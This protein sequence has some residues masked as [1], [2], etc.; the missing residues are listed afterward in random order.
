[1]KTLKFLS[2]KITNTI[3]SLTNRNSLN[4][5]ILTKSIS[6]ENST[7]DYEQK[8]ETSIE[9]TKLILESIKMENNL[10][11]NNNSSLRKNIDKLDK[12]LSQIINSFFELTNFNQNSF[13]YLIES[14]LIPILT[15]NI[16]ITYI[17]TISNSIIQCLLK[18]IFIDNK[19][20][21]KGNL[22][23]EIIIMN[24]QVIGCIKK[25]IFEFKN[26]LNKINIIS[27]NT[28]LFNFIN[29]GIVPFMDN[30]LLKIIKYPN[31]YYGLINDSSTININ[32]DLLLFE[33]LIN[34][35][36]FEHQIKN[37]T[38]RAL[39][40]KNLIRFLNNFDFK[41]KIELMQKVINYLISILIDYY[42][43][44]LLLSIKKIDDNYKIVNNI[45]LEINENDIIQITTDDTISYLQFFNI[46]TFSFSEYDLKNYLMDLLFNNFFSQY[47]L[48]E[49]INLSNNISYQVRSTLLIQYIYFLSK[50]IK[51]NEIN[52]LF[53]YF[54]FG[55]NL[56]Q[57]NIIEEDLNAN[58]NVNFR[59]IISKS[60]QNYESIRAFFTLILESNNINQ[61]SLLIKTLTNLANNIPYIFMSEMIV[62][63]YLFYLNKKKL[64]E[65]DFDDIIDNLIKKPEQL[66]LLEIV[67][68]LIPQYFNIDPLNWINYF[69]KNIDLNC[70][71][72]I[73]NINQ[74]NTSYSQMFNNDSSLMNKSD[75]NNNSN[76]SYYKNMVNI[77]NYSFSDCNNESMLSSRNDLNESLF[78]N[79]TKESENEII[80]ISLENKF[81]Y[82][83]NSVTFASR[84]KFFEILVKKYK[85][86][87]DNK[88]E[89]NLY[90][91]EFF[92]EI[93]SFPTPLAKGIEG[94]QLYNIYTGITYAKKSN[95]K[96]FDIS[97]TG[98]LHNIKNQL[99]KK[100]MNNFTK[101]EI[102]NFCILMNENGNDLLVMTN[103][104][105][106]DLAKKIEFLK[107][108]KLYNEIFKDFISNTF[109]KILTEESN[110]YW[111]KGIHNN[112]KINE[113]T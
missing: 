32:L 41:N 21:S 51:N 43:N 13:Q 40:R 80:N 69:I 74:I 72:G 77:T 106:S 101:E 27:V 30:L 23:E 48:E 37:R 91:T 65:K 17:N 47:I 88:Y 82:I 75:G 59:K 31:F 20:L 42:Q 2:N 29:N 107:N 3:G 92:N 57:K 12:H 39:I 35:L 15:E 6:K 9:K 71:R 102:N 111:I 49:I 67:K 109:G 18:L 85:K 4:S 78:G 103:D 8:M 87:I 14:K 110:R 64:T 55:F 1:M 79:Q 81:S 100:V 97:A 11:K 46:L 70:Q 105:N 34:L 113:S 104:L 68:I 38:S 99:D 76:I 56:E 90:L 52:E 33:I 61:L 98:L 94:Q 36:K 45:P 44:F 96:F 24:T 58:T 50:Y 93:A 83:L 73:N 62:P 108:V 26:I 66:G 95:D 53:F 54:L 10:D 7:Y 84:V 89:E 112:N 16:N 5:N 25:I 19:I 22:K 86:Y 28:E 60:N 63:Y